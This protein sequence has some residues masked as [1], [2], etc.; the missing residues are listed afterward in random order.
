M[1]ILKIALTIP[2][3]AVFLSS[4]NTTLTSCTGAVF[5]RLLCVLAVIIMTVRKG[6]QSWGRDSNMGIPECT[7]SYH[8]TATFGLLPIESCE[9]LVKQ[10]CCFRR[11][12]FRSQRAV[13]RSAVLDWN[14]LP[15][16]GMVMQLVEYRI[17]FLLWNGDTRCLCA[18]RVKTLPMFQ[19]QY[20]LFY[21][22][23]FDC[24]TKFV[25]IL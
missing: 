22:F 14:F 18:R 23:C 6:S 1:S 24:D 16:I 19:L 20:H 21:S 2:V 10:N 8:S 5:C 12:W 7:E 15:T 4:R 3:T 9:A 25:Q 11:V 13:G 17:Y